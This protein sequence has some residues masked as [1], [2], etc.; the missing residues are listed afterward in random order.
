MG[1]PSGCH[2]IHEDE[3]ERDLLIKTSVALTLKR[4]ATA[5]DMLQT[6]ASSGDRPWPKHF[7]SSR[8]RCPRP[9]VILARP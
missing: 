5:L 4:A 2:S 6:C 9:Q 8:L 3:H 7:R 1:S